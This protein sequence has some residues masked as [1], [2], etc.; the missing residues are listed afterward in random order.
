MLLLFSCA[1]QAPP[2]GGP[3]DSSGPIVLSI[4]PDFSHEILSNKQKIYI[5]FDELIDSKSLPNS[6][7]IYPKIKINKSIKN[8]TLIIEPIDRWP[9][10]I[11]IEIT[12]SRSL[13]DY[14]NNNLDETIQ[15]FFNSISK[16]STYNINGYLYNSNEKIIQMGLY[17]W[18]VSFKDD[19]PYKVVQ[20]NKDGYYNFKYVSPGEYIIFATAD[21]IIDPYR[22]IRNNKYGLSSEN[23]LEVINDNYAKNI[24]LDG[25]II[26]D[27]VEEI[28]CINSNY[29]KLFTSEGKIID[30]FADK[31]S[32]KGDT[33]SF[34]VNM[35]NELEEYSINVN[36]YVIPEVYDTISPSIISN[37]IDKDTL[38]IDFSEPINKDSLKIYDIDNPNQLINYRFIS[39][40]KI[41]IN[42]K[43][44]GIKLFAKDIL[45]YS[46]NHM[47]DSVNIIN[48]IDSENLVDN[49]SQTSIN[50]I[51]KSNS[52]NNKI[53]IQ[54]INQDS[55]L[56]YSTSNNYNT[57]K[58]SNIHPGHYKIWAFSMDNKIDSLRYFSGTID[59]YRPSSKFIFLSDTI[60]VR[61]NWDIEGLIIDFN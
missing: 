17:K 13:S 7:D 15:L 52:Y 24:Y 8:S 5:I 39:P 51:I 46:N 19:S 14:Q 43:V 26:R 27:K 10:N 45:D 32:E 55:S 41:F 21:K 35:Q 34:S 33:I 28:E 29:Y 23:Y 56:Y 47:L 49:D 16:Q 11:P 3:L 54:A 37:F 6:I 57:F 2:N 48:I 22:N 59:P 12:I 50:G 30:Y 38:F 60:E 44:S 58:F 4:K 25:P 36:Q 42:N 1:S 53:I 18:P 61:K 9:E 20:S 40:K 31:K